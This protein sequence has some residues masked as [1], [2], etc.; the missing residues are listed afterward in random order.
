MPK[1]NIIY[2]APNDDHYIWN[3]ASLDKLEKAEQE[4]LRFSGKSFKEEELANAIADC[5]E[6][7]ARTFPK[8]PDPE[9]GVVEIAVSD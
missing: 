5:K 4:I 6:T 9:I 2:T 7:I 3:G 1:Y 8:D